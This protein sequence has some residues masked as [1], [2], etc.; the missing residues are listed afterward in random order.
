M[1]YNIVKEVRTLGKKPK[2]KEKPTA[3]EIATLI[4]EGIIAIAA[5]IEALK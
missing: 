5:L 2:R 3:Y 4:F 1:W